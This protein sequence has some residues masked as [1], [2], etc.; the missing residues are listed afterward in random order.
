MAVGVCAVKLADCGA[1]VSDGRESHKGGALGTSGAVVLDGEG[2]WGG[3]AVKE[4][5]LRS[6]VSFGR[7]REAKE[8]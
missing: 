1:G 6:K 3:D 5:L 2:E 7:S 4:I 8:V